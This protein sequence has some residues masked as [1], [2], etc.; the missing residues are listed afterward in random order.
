MPYK[1]GNNGQETVLW[2]FNADLYGRECLFFNL[3]LETDT[4]EGATHPET[5]RFQNCTNSGTILQEQHNT[6]V[7]LPI[8]SLTLERD[9]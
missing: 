7:N 2:A 4:T 1:D 3:V 8:A 6:A 5:L 9:C